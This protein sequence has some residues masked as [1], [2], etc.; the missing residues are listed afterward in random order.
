MSAAVN[1][2]S[3]R[4]KF[5]ERYESLMRH[6]DMKMEKTN[7]AKGNENG[8]VESLHRHLKK[9][10]EQALLLRGSCDFSTRDA[11]SIFVDDLVRQKNRGRQERLLEELD[12]LRTLPP[13][14][15]ESFQ[16]VRV[17]VNSGSLIRVQ[18]NR[19]SVNSRLVGESVDVRVFAEHLEVWYGQ[20]QQDRLPR[21]RGA[22]K[23]CINYRHII[24][25]L[26][27]KPGAFENYR[28]QEDL[29]PTSRFR[30]AYDQLRELHSPSRAASKYLAILEI[31]ARDNETLV[32]DALRV[33]LSRDTT[34]DV[35]SVKSILAAEEPL[36]LV[37]AVHVG[38]PDLSLFDDLLTDKEVCDG[39]NQY[40]ESQTNGAFAGTAPA[41]IP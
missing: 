5:T 32:D 3:D 39:D 7:V 31:A 37:T 21:L 16:E 19:Y 41:D 17:R 28:Y 30:M 13:R 34:V 4:K 10:I 15:L 29:F 36:P 25:W 26:I 9:A 1:N 35:E 11:Y 38:D 8:D 20:K 23:H 18:K 6:Y 12:A 14:R 27:R 24:D 2:L 33:L 22:H 40:G